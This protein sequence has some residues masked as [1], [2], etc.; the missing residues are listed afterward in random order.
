[1][2]AE[3]WFDPSISLGPG[4]GEALQAFEEA[5][6]GGS[7]GAGPVSELVRALRTAGKGAFMTALKHP[8]A[9][10]EGA[11]ER[12]VEEMAMRVEKL[13]APPV[14]LLKLP[15]NMKRVPSPLETLVLFAEEEAELLNRGR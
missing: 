5:V 15:E 8:I 7:G 3:A 2:R 11:S 4:A 1:V 14:H 13:E 12:F 10:K 9:V 6:S